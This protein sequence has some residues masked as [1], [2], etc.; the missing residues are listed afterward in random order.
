MTGRRPPARRNSPTGPPHTI[1]HART[2]GAVLAA[3]L[4][5]APAQSVGCYPERKDRVATPAFQEC[6][7]GAIG[8]GG[9][10]DRLEGDGN[11]V[12]ARHQR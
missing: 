1:E 12:P 10:R 6:S 5:P 8:S 3:H 2:V 7:S 4:R 11:P 9:L